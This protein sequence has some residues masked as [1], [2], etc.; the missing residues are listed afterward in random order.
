M[1]RLALGLSL[2]GC[3]LAPATSLALGLGS[4]EVRT[5]LNQPLQA[6]IKLVGTSPGE[7]QGMTVRLASPQLFKQVGIPRPDYLGKLQFK[8][9][10]GSGGE[11]YIQVTTRNAVK[12]PFLDFLLEVNWPGGRLLRE[13]TVLLNPPNYMQGKPEASVTT[14]TAAPAPTVKRAP[15]AQS[16]GTQAKASKP[17]AMP[18]QSSS[19]A[20]SYRVKKG[21]TLIQVAGR[22]RPNQS[23]SV[24]QMMVA[25]VRANP[26]AFIHGNINGLKQGYVLRMP[27]S[28]TLSGISQGEANAEVRKQN[29][30]WRQYAARMAGNTVAQSQLKSGGEAASSTT[31]QASSSASGSKLKIMGTE[32]SASG[33]SKG[34][35]QV[36]MAGGNEA[37]KLQ[38]EL[39]LAQEATASNQQKISD[40]ESR[41]KA[42]QGI[43]QKQQKLIDLKNQQLADLQHKLAANATAAAPSAVQPA[44]SSTRTPAAQAAPATTAAMAPA[45]TVEQPAAAAPAAPST[46]APAAST[47]MAAP[48][49]S[50][51]APAT[52]MAT[53][54]QVKPE[55]QPAP[56]AKQPSKPAATPKPVA[57]APK[58]VPQP[59]LISDLLGNP[60]MLMGAGGVGLL[61]LAL[62]W[63]VVRRSSKARAAAGEPETALAEDTDENA[64]FFEDGDA[65]EQEDESDAFGE[66]EEAAQ[67]EEDE[68][69][70]T[71]VEPGEEESERGEAK[72]EAGA[73]AAEA[74]DDVLAEADV[75]IAYGLFQQ[76]EDVL[77]KALGSDPE[78]NDY[79]AKLLE[80]H[81]GAKN[82]SAFE[83]EAKELHDALPHPEV[84]PLWIRVATLGKEL[85]PDNPLF[86]GTDTGG[87]TSADVLASEPVGDEL[88][89][90][91]SEFDLGDLSDVDAAGD[92]DLGEAEAEDGAEKR[93]DEALDLGDLDLGE[94]E[95]GEAAADTGIEAT[96][97]DDALDLGDLDLGEDEAV[98]LGAPADQA[99]S[100]E[101]E[102]EALD[103]GGGIQEESPADSGTSAELATEL[104]EEEKPSVEEQLDDLDFDLDDLD[105]TSETSTE[106]ESGA[107]DDTGLDLDLEDLP[108]LGSEEGEAEGDDF[109]SLDLDTGAFDLEAETSGLED[110]TASGEAV[111]ETD[112]GLSLDDLP[113]PEAGLEAESATADT[114]T[115]GGTAAG[116]EVATKLDLAR[117]YI[118]MGD[119][120][121]AQSTLEEVVAEGS[122]E[123]KQQAEELLKQLA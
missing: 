66:A 91:E 12:Q 19:T 16:S 101:D 97:E 6:N 25:L 100:A 51:V 4:I 24:N 18:T 42:L 53:P 11:P 37:T 88:E 64:P 36:A 84:D 80:C 3:L 73:K 109:E 49:S 35:S 89:L 31:K 65:A 60:N 41:L 62:L 69:G 75:Y 87:M 93:A 45:T 30:L 14:P 102:F 15:A 122:D 27:P 115:M 118:D 32:P 38:H 1:R 67:P 43:V 59:S 98:D 23:T 2:M 121:G 90:G 55:S 61:L 68:F 82:V 94:D 26:Q 40:L 54:A 20:T 71:A 58:P 74:A 56:E 85:V 113:E 107:D 7:V 92:F 10:S 108:E 39:S 105:I 76:A 5:T 110:A 120:E 103:L 79:R 106:T 114:D 9:Q 33:D 117:A 17:A 96:E 77:R 46:M 123:Q 81:F 29:G 95:L 34:S 21:D 78:R 8:V 22:M 99:A 119:T 52:T 111:T 104:L 50:A 57:P 72:A 44:A 28:G 86:T 63:L 48:T 83:S 112:Q 70:E 47:T 13:Y 116:D